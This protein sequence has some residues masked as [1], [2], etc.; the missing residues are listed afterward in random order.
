MALHEGAAAGVLAGEPYGD[1]FHD[2]RTE[3]RK[4]AEAP[5]DAALTGHLLTLLQELLELG[6]HGEA[7]RN[8]QMG[9]ADAGQGVR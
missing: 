2:E 1:A 4:L 7:L 3:G 6:V 8:V 5:V 9:L